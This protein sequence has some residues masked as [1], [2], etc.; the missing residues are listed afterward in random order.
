MTRECYAGSLSITQP[1]PTTRD[2][3]F[4]ALF[5]QIV[6]GESP[7]CG[8]TCVSDRVTSTMRLYDENYDVIVYD[9]SEENGAEVALRR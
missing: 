9:V 8:L 4:A 5:L 7:K 3:K 1:V 2:V 6:C